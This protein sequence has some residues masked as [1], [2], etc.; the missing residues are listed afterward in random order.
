MIRHLYP[1]IAINHAFE[2]AVHELHQ[3]YVE[4]SGNT[5]G[6]PVIYFHGGPGGG[7][8]SEHR[9]YFNPEKYHIILF[10]QRG[11]GR[12]KPSPSVEQ[13]TLVDLIHDI[14]KIRQHLHIDK[15][16]V[17]GGS[18]GTTLALAYAIENPQAV[19][20]FVL[21][22]IFLG[23]KEEYDWLYKP[24]GAAKFFPEY[25]QD[26]IAPLAKEQ[27]EDPLT[28]YQTLL[29]SPNELLKAAASKAWY[30]WESR[31]S[32]I[33]HSIE[34]LSHIDDHH[35]AFCMAYLSNYYFVNKC[36][37]K[38][39]L[40]NNIDKIQ[41]L[42]ATILHGRYDMVCQI[43]QAS[44]L[45]QAWSNA[46]LN[47]LPKAGHSGFESQTMAAFCYATDSMANLFKDLIK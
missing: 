35:Q 29:N 46:E 1:H 14:E 5:D 22:G 44:L 24:S 21:R 12:S 32:S 40:L 10:D 45:T 27:L 42:P 33:E 16:L 18:W 17:C 20:G 31:L 28:G 41:H 36:F 30:V 3:L 23:T 15:W 34:S 7:C 47:V 2:L 39:P 26:F 25:Y 6:I 4:C 38:E 37:L 8:S 9:R 43:K 19:L 13:N 11:C